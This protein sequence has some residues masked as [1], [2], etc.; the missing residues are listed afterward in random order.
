MNRF[1]FRKNTEEFYDW[2]KTIYQFKEIVEFNCFG[3]SKEW[4]ESHQEE[5]EEARSWL[6]LYRNYIK[7]LTPLEKRYINRYLND[8]NSDEFRQVDVKEL[9]NR[10]LTTVANQP[11]NCLKEISKNEVGLA[12]SSARKEAGYSRRVMASLLN[13]N[14]ETLKA[15]EKGTR[16]LPFDIYFKLK[17]IINVSFGA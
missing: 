15:Y 1:I 17:Q 16:T 13:V 10:W 3:G 9:I 6:T 8:E 14:P 11:L 12:I 7:G 5:Y 4:R 2:M